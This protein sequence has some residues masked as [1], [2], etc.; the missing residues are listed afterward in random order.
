MAAHTILFAGKCYSRRTGT[1]NQRKKTQGVHTHTLRRRD[2]ST[3][4]S[5]RKG[6]FIAARHLFN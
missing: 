1:S 4:N 2:D 3:K 5:W 6:F